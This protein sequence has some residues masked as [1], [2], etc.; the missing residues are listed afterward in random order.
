MPVGQRTSPR[1]SQRKR[2]SVLSDA[3]IERLQTSLSRLAHP[4]NDAERVGNGEV[5]YPPTLRQLFE[6]SGETGDLERAMRAIAT[7]PS[8]HGNLRTAAKASRGKSAAYFAQALAFL[9]EDTE[10]VAGSAKLLRSVL[11]ST[12]TA[13]T[14]IFGITQLLERV[15]EFLRQPF[16]VVLRGHAASGRPPSGVGVVLESGSPKF[17]LL[18]HAALGDPAAQDDAPAVA[19]PQDE[20]APDRGVDRITPD[21]PP[22]QIDFE[23]VF[24]SAFDRLDVQSGSHNYVLLHDLRRALPDLSRHEFDEQLND[25]RR[26]KLFSLDS[27]DGRHVRLTAEQLDAGIREASSLLVYV[28]RRAQ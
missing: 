7:N 16:A 11:Q 14:N 27:A 1:K 17:F 6:L 25:L 12:R 5:E 23:R 2:K 4:Q 10:R 19:P 22:P 15:P 21:P 13:R 26:S 9:P 3:Q 18:A 8:V 24:R 20:P 28:A